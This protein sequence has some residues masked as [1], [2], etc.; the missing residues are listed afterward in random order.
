MRKFSANFVSMCANSIQWSALG[1]MTISH[2]DINKNFDNKFFSIH[3]WL[4]S[5]ILYVYIFYLCFSHFRPVIVTVIIFSFQI[6]SWNSSTAH[7][8][9][10]WIRFF[11][12]FDIFAY[13]LIYDLQNQQRQAK[14]SNLAYEKNKEKKNER[15]SVWKRRIK[16]TA[17]NWKVDA[18]GMRSKEKQRK[19]K[20]QSTTNASWKSIKKEKNNVKKCDWTGVRA[21]TK[22]ILK[23]LSI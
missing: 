9:N 1:Y 13:I 17:D 12:C 4:F 7:M 11:I 3:F 10:I 19:K 14:C 2:K 15:E 21:T 16:K 8:A 23:A 20:L 6:F 22:S 5:S 18:G